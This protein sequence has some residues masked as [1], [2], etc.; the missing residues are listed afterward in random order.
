M[1][2]SD[3]MAEQ[4][5]FKEIIADAFQDRFYTSLLH[6]SVLSV[7]QEFM[8]FIEKIIEDLEIDGKCPEIKCRRGCSYCCYSHLK[9]MPV[10]ALLINAFIKTH[11]TSQKLSGLKERIRR[12]L[13]LT[14]NKTIEEKFQNKK[15][16]PCVFLDNDFC[17]IYPVR[18]FICRAWNSLDRTSCESAFHADTYHAEIEA[19]SAR[20]FCFGLARTI[21]VEL[22]QQMALHSNKL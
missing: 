15:K 10:E 22:S 20:N 18:P 8:E 14:G 7:L 16:T 1:T 3:D 19:S 2:V 9:I 13:Q 5:R 21:F 11:F 6:G 12:N 4:E 17:S